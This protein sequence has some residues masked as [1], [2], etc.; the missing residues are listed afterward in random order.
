MIFFVFVF[1]FASHFG[2]ILP[3][4]SLKRFDFFSRD[5]CKHSGVCIRSGVYSTFLC[6][7]ILFSWLGWKF[8]Y[9]GHF[10]DENHSK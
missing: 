2:H 1:G 3:F 7:C 4:A 10:F 6:M 9:E 8:E 5:F